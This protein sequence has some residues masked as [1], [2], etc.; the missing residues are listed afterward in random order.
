M[1]GHTNTIQC[2]QQK[3]ASVKPIDDQQGMARCTNTTQHRP[4]TTELYL[5]TF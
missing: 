5:Y 1:V 3:S 4:M 2:H